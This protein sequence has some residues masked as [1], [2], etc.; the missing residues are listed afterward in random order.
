MASLSGG[1]DCVNAARR[2]R[3]GRGGE[4]KRTGQIGRT[5]ATR[6]A[7]SA[8]REQRIRVALIANVVIGA[9]RQRPRRDREVVRN[10][11]DEIVGINRIRPELLTVAA[12]VMTWSP[13][14]S[15]GAAPAIHGSAHSTRAQR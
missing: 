14:G 12:P 1:R 15:G 11:A 4:G 6:K 13:V 9:D 5:I 3:V 7:D 8:R 2:T 10:V